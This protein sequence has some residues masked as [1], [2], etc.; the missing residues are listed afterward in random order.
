MPSCAK[1]SHRDC[2]ERPD[3]KWIPGKG[4]R[5]KSYVDR[6]GN[7]NSVAPPSS[8]SLSASQGHSYTTMGPHETAFPAVM[9]GPS[10]HRNNNVPNNS[11]P[12]NNVSVNDTRMLFERIMT[13]PDFAPGG[14]SSS[15]P[16]MVPQPS[17]SFHP[18][19]K[20]ATTTTTTTTTVNGNLALAKEFLTDWFSKFYHRPFNAFQDSALL[21]TVKDLIDQQHS[22]GEIQSHMLKM[23]KINGGYQWSPS[24]NVTSQNPSTTTTNNNNNNIISSPAANNE[25]QQQQQQGQTANNANVKAF[26]DNVVATMARRIEERYK[27]G[28]G[29]PQLQNY[30]VQ[31]ARYLGSNGDIQYKPDYDAFVKLWARATRSDSVSVTM[32]ICSEFAW[33]MSSALY[34]S[35]V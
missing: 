11:V 28:I 25:Q 29:M 17:S 21:N 31:V 1:L 23:T 12:N 20:E 24:S 33:A 27:L 18:V 30:L 14:S 32:T 22:R 5:K 3:C 35:Y 19:S 4:C 16:M 7:A 2:L 6:N 8:S 15:S 26:M 10:S 9:Y 13:S 34:L